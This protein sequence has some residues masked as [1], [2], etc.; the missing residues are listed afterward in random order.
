MTATVRPATATDAAELAAVA[1][2]TF[3][4]ACPPGTTPEAM[5][6]FIS[7][8]LR[9][10]HFAAYLTDPARDVLL[11]EVDG[12]PAGYTMLV[13]GEPRD[14]DVLASITARPTVELS[15]CYVRAEHHGRG[16]A[17]ALM[18]ASIDA[19]RARGA[20]ALWLGVNQQNERAN[21]FYA[22]SGFALVGTKRFLVGGHYED[23][24]VRELLL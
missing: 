14:A 13:A 7:D 8:N 5:Q 23:D 21:A 16:V 2:A 3:P 18:A 19:A 17:S 24:F 10:S 20:A 6:S 4:L 22:K 11:A 15:K 9:E 12:V 1:A